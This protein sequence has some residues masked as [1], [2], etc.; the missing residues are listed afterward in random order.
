MSGEKGANLAPKEALHGGAG[1][2]GACGEGGK[3]G[4]S[5]SQKSEVTVNGILKG[6]V[7]STSLTRKPALSWPTLLGLVFSQWQFVQVL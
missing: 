4:V 5:V 3:G 6:A 2:I 7:Q 1:E